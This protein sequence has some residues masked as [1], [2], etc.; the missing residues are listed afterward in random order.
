MMSQSQKLK[1]VKLSQK[2]RKKLKTA[3]SSVRG[4][5]DLKKLNDIL[6]EN[7][8]TEDSFSLND[9]NDNLIKKVIKLLNTN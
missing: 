9:I 2:L 8:I 7:D 6:K 5:C 1:T 3:I 4:G